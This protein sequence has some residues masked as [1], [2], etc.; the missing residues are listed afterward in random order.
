[1]R[2]DVDAA[3]P[4]EAMQLS[5]P[6][7]KTIQIPP[8]SSLNE[9]NITPLLDLAFFRAAGDLH[10][11]HASSCRNDLEMNLP[12]PPKKDEQ[13]KPPAKMNRIWA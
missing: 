5:A 4:D 7:E 2:F 1:M 10:H 9:L 11:H 3:Q 6:G 8:R 13:P 12:S